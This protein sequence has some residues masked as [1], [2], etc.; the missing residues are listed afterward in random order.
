MNETI[1][2]GRYKD[3]DGNVFEVLGVAIS[4]DG[5]PDVVVYLVDDQMV[6]STVDVWQELVQVPRYRR[7]A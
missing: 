6:V 2:A 7:V 1:E 3:I 5:G 4:T